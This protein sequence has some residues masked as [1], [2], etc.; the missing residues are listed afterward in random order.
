MSGEQNLDLNNNIIH[1][2]L[3][4]IIEIIISSS[5]HGEH[6]VERVVIGSVQTT[7]RIW[8]IFSHN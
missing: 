3:S 6:G 5:F 1:I 4:I 8:A 2:I 7:R